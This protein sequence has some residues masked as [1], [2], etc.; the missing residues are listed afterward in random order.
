MLIYNDKYRVIDENMS[1]SQV[2]ARKNKN[3]RDHNWMIN[4]IV[5]E[6]VRKNIQAEIIVSDYKQAFDTLNTESVLTDLYDSGV[7]DNELNL[8]YEA[9]STHFVKVNSPVGLTGETTI[10]NKSM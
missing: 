3:I 8:I 6:A 5:L 7:K 2:G 1:C 10:K 9:D 4:N